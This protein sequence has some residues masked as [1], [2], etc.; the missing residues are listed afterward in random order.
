[1]KTI[2]ISIDEGM[3]FGYKTTTDSEELFN[4]LSEVL[5]NPVVI[6]F[7]IFLKNKKI[8]EIIVLKNLEV[9]EKFR[10]QGIGS[11][12]LEQ[13]CEQSAGIPIFLVVDNLNSQK[14]GFI[15]EN[16]YL[17]WGFEPTGFIT[18]SGPIFIRV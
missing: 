18:L 1:M 8:Q 13:F 9:E 6:E 15:L 2:S 3:V 7:I 11:K 4:Y 16:W 14:E 5:E 17:N 10:G 12:L